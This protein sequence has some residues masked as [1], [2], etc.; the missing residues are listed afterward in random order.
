M[1]RSMMARTAPIRSVTG[2]IRAYGAASDISLLCFTVS[3]PPF[4]WLAAVMIRTILPRFRPTT[5][6]GGGSTVVTQEKEHMCSIK[7]RRRRRGWFRPAVDMD[8]LEVDQHQLR[9]LEHPVLLFSFLSRFR[10]R[11]LRMT[12]RYQRLWQR[13]LLMPDRTR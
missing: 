4:A 1:M 7:A 9:G 13:Q 10:L 3:S 6:S 5:S 2:S 12:R 11:L 8:P